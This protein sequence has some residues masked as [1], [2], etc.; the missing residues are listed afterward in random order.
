WFDTK[1]LK[2]W[3]IAG[4]AEAEQ[5]A[6]GFIAES[7]RF[8]CGPKDGRA[9]V[10]VFNTLPDDRTAT[11]FVDIDEHKNYGVYDKGRELPSQKDNG[12]LAFAVH[13]GGLSRRTYE[14]REKPGDVPV[15]TEVHRGPYVFQNDIMSVTVLPD[16]RIASLCSKLSGERLKKPGNLIKGKLVR[17]D[18]TETWI[19][20]EHTAESMLV[21]KG[22]LYDKI[23]IDGAIEDIPYRLIIRLAHG[24][25]ETVDFEL[26]LGFN[27]H[28]IGDFYHDESKLNIY[29]D[30]NQ[31]QPEIVIDEPFGWITQRPERPLL[32]A[33]FTGLFEN[34]TGLVFRH[35]GTPKSWVS[36]SVYANLI[37]WGSKNFTNRFHWFWSAVNKYD[38][39]LDRACHY[40]YSVSIAENG[41]VPAIVKRTSGD[42]TPLVALRGDAPADS[43]SLLTVRNESLVTTAVEPKEGGIAVRMYNASDKPCV[44]EFD[45]SLEFLKKTDAAGR[46]TESAEAK[47]FE[48]FELLFR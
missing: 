40:N 16:G 47:P 11:A 14:I 33:N 29:W 31:R 35:T 32:A 3:A 4:I 18:A 42:I 39:R 43:V 45:T 8:M 30:L 12:K 23:M 20:N 22:V 48:I 24:C 38:M 27:M 9:Y 5:A 26:D 19:T 41:A 36:G 17:E 46:A 10:N 1:E 28:E 7:A 25:S 2:E 15:I 44:P 13:A 6:S 21:E 34:G 37:A